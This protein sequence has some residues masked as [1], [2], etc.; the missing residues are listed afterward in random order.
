MDSY[1]TPFL[2][3][4]SPQ[5]LIRPGCWSKLSQVI[6]QL[7]KHG[8]VQQKPERVSVSDDSLFQS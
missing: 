2:L 7:Q 3:T 1:I 6:E 8:P 4:M 5:M